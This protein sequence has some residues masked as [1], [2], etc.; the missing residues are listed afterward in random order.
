MLPEIKLKKNDPIK[1]F[2]IYCQKILLTYASY[3]TKI[4]GFDQADMQ[5]I[6]KYNKG[7]RYLFCVIDT[8]SNYP[9]FVPLKHT[10]KELPKYFRQ[11]KKETK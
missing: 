10:K 7:V 11:F 9:W 5:L 3:K 1:G 8:F 2:K 6:T 4:W